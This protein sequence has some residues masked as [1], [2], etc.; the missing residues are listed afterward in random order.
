MGRRRVKS[1]EGTATPTAAVPALP[2]SVSPEQAPKAQTREAAARVLLALGDLSLRA[3][4]RTMLTDCSL[5][6]AEAGSL[7]DSIRA[8]DG[9][10]FDAMI[11]DLTLPD[12]AGLDLVRRLALE[13]QPTK[14]IVCAEAPSLD[15]AVSAMRLG[16]VDLLALP[17]IEAEAV[18]SVTAAIEMSR[19]ERAQTRRIER[20]KRICRRLNSARQQVTSQVDVLCNDLVGAYR[21]LADKVTHVALASEF[22]SIV[23]QELDI[24]SLLRTALEYLLGKTGP[25]NAAVF[26]PSNHSDF[27]LGAYVNYDCP[28]DTADVLL[29]HLADVI[30]PRFQEEEEVVVFDDDSELAQWIGDDANWLSDSRVIVFSCRYEGECLAVMTLFRDRAVPFPEELTGQLGVMAHIFA[31]QLARIIRIHHRHTPGKTW[32]GWDSFDEE[33]DGLGG[34]AA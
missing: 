12:G 26:L 28:R 21:E 27:T 18:A 13:E 10:S 9:E 24:E 8:L 5:S 25:T 31:R 20:L 17:L 30:A 33:D 11:T 2:A 23:Q 34:L 29:D 1:R 14:T 3:R 22:G 15:D 7:T 19:S 4:L 32:T 16:V 6:C